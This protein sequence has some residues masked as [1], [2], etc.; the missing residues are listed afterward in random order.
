MC[1]SDRIVTVG[2]ESHAT[3]V[4]II[5]RTIE[6]K[7]ACCSFGA[8]SHSNR[9]TSVWL[10]LIMYLDDFFLQAILMLVR[11]ITTARA[12]FATSWMSPLTPTTPPKPIDL[13]LRSD[14]NNRLTLLE[15]VIISLQ[16]KNSPKSSQCHGNRW[17]AN[18]IVWIILFMVHYLLNGQQQ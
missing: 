7:Q 16:R 2:A 5:T 9:R 12:Q 14:I 11:Q 4:D 10:K 3:R 1:H 15:V 8:Y 6:R 13:V 18:V 17:N